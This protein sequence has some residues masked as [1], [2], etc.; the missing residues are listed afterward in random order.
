[1]AQL[2]RPIRLRRILSRHSRRSRVIPRRPRLTAVRRPPRDR[3]NRTNRRTVRERHFR[4]RVHRRDTRTMRPRRIPRRL[5]T[6]AVRRSAPTPATAVR[7]CRTS[8]IAAMVRLR[9]P[10]IGV[11]GRV[12][13]TRTIAV[14]DRVRHTATAAQVRPIATTVAPDRALLTPAAPTRLHGPRRE[15]AVAIMRRVVVAAHTVA[16]EDPMAGVED[17]AKHVW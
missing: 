4:L 15:V 16:E 1:M 14:M 2:V 10:A 17:T 3:M 11:T 5:T 6:T 8:A 9:P 7:Q 12:R 13:R